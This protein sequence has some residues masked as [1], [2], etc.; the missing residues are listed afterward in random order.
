[1]WWFPTIRVLL[2]KQKPVNIIG[3]LNPLGLVITYPHHSFLLGVP[4]RSLVR[5][6]LESLGLIE[7][8]RE[9]DLVLSGQGLELGDLDLPTVR[10]L[11]EKSLTCLNEALEHM[12]SLIF[13][14]RIGVVIFASNFWRLFLFTFIRL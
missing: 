3:L 1:M 6:V 5:R 14:W 11:R 10:V 9:L 12:S 7:H 13:S 4:V 2:A 8:L